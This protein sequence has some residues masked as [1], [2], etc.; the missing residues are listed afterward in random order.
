[1]NLV[2]FQSEDE[3]KFLPSSDP[4]V[5]HV[6]DVLRMK[7]F[8]TMYVGVLNGKRGLAKI[9]KEDD[10]GLHFEIAWEEKVFSFL[11]IHLV[12]GL[13][14]PQTARKIL[15]ECTTLGVKS[16]S[17]FQA[18]KSD[19]NY[20]QSKLWKTDE[21]QRILLR[22]AEQAFVTIVPN[23]SHYEN[24]KEF[25]CIRDKDTDVVALDNYE[26]TRHLRDYVKKSKET[27]LVIGPEGG[28]DKAERTL[29]R[30]ND[31]P[32]YHLGERVLRSE[33]ACVSAIGLLLGKV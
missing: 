1:M 13:P 5:I 32:L 16:I 18:E 2:L 9:V 4:R 3:A 33:T 22:G 21:W 29:L 11:P 23:V 14:R 6:R 15:S 27:I 24:L 17:F 28:F 7:V 20:I 10:A 25:L 31:I 8:D 12:V 26:A 19:P 30:G